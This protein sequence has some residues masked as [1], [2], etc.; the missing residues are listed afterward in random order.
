MIT[1]KTIDLDGVNFNEGAVILINKP[2]GWTSFKVVDKVRR[3]LKIK[4]VGHAGTLDPKATGLLILCTGK[5]TKNIE[6]FQNQ[7]KEYRGKIYFGK[8]T[9]TMDMESIEQASEEKDISYLNI[10]LIREKA[11][12]FIGEIEQVPPSY[13]AIWVD[14]KRAYELARKGK[15][16][17]LKPRKVQVFKFEILN[18]NPPIAEFEVVCSKGTYI[19]SL[20]N[21]LGQKLGCGAFL[22]QLERTK[23][24]NFSV[25]DALN[26]SELQNLIQKSLN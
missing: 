22:Y 2:E 11:K 20:A 13:S 17:N 26:I 1:K 12:E 7:I 6:E 25:D 14:G 16:F 3:I 10:D 8:T 5:L 24:G 4:K 19:R 18:F 15:D 23:I 21:D 9:P